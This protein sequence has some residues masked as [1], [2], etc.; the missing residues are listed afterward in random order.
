MKTIEDAAYEYAKD[1]DYPAPEN[2]WYGSDY[3]QMKDCLEE[4]F[5]AGANHIMSLPLSDRLTA[6]EREMI[7]KLYTAA[8]GGNAPFSRGF[9]TAILRIFGKSMFEEEGGSDV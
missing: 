3:M 9:L 4:V 5:R 7:K 1:V 2:G 6:D 8:S